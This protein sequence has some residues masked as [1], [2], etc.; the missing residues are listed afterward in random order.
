MSD[1]AGSVSTGSD[2][3][4][5]NFAILNRR[6]TV[7]QI[8]ALGCAW[9]L[10][11]MVAAYIASAIVTAPQ[12]V[13][14]FPL[15]DLDDAVTA[16]PSFYS[17][18]MDIF[19]NAEYVDLTHAFG[20]DTPV[21]SAFQTME[22][23]AGIAGVAIEGFVTAGSELT[24][25]DHGFQTT[26]YTLTTDQY[27][28]QLDPPAHW[29]EFGATIS[30]LPATFAVRPLVVIDISLKVQQDEK[31]VAKISDI[32][33]WERKYGAIP[34]GSV[35]FFRSDWSLQW[36]QYKKKGLPANFPGVSLDVLKL[37][38]LERGILF[39]GHEPLDTDMTPYLEGE[40]WLMHN[41]YA[42][43]EGLTNLDKIPEMGCLVSIGFA[44]PQG[45]TGG[46]ARFVAICPKGSTK[47]GQTLDKYPGAPL[48]RQP[49][50]LRRN[51][52]GVLE[53]TPFAIPTD[54]CSTNTSM[55]CQKIGVPVW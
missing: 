7:R 37:L 9:A 8:V 14:Q 51:K 11:I 49:H 2:V 30:D 40:A 39:H 22:V 20:P 26:N 31:Y 3:E 25:R 48:S 42:Q 5:V 50:P 23:G 19:F 28:T 6:G 21:W 53:P 29:N 33:T 41:D 10:S 35:V 15:R 47:G 36:D 16:A 44:K 45:G 13:G 12:H 24:Y 17:A 18:Y 1:N 32:H 43:A 34:P 27:G 55:G 54:Y 4:Q 38:H 52:Y 46:F